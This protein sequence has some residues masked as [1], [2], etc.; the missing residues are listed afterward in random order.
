[1]NTERPKLAH[2]LLADAVQWMLDAPGQIQLGP[3]NMEQAAA[4]LDRVAEH[5]RLSLQNYRIAQKAFEGASFQGIVKGAIVKLDEGDTEAARKFLLTLVNVIAWSP[6]LPLDQVAA[7]KAEPEVTGGSWR[8]THRHA[9]GGEYRYLGS[10]A[11]KGNEG[12]QWELAEFYEDAEGRLRWTSPLRW[13][14]R[15]ALIEEPAVG[16][17]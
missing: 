15:F 7:P 14:T 4:E 17:G 5:L 13:Q 1:M 9:E 2:E 11:G 16:E 12:E 3:D 8:P 10:G 6:E